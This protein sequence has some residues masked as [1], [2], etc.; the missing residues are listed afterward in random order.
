M[1]RAQSHSDAAVI[2]EA[3]LL[4]W[5]LSIDINTLIQSGSEPH[6][7]E[8]MRRLGRILESVSGLL[9]GRVTPAA[10]VAKEVANESA[11][12]ALWP[13]NLELTS[14]IERFLDVAGR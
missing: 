11:S 4:C 5:Q 3:Q 14:A 9:I 13:C 6:E 10:L 7:W 12:L 8:V 1:F 2:M